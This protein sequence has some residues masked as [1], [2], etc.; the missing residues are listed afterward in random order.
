MKLGFKLSFFLLIAVTQLTYSQ[1]GEFILDTSKVYWSSPFSGYN[2]D[3]AFD[4]TNYLVVWSDFRNNYPYQADIYASRVNQNGDVLDINGIIVCSEIDYQ[5]EVSIAFDGNN[6]LAVWED[7]RNGVTQS[8]IYGARITQTGNVLDPN[9]FVIAANTL[10]EEESPAVSFDGTNYLVTWA[11][12]TGSANNIFGARVSTSGIVIDNPGFMISNT[13]TIQSN[14]E[15]EFDGTNYLV[16]WEDERN[17]NG[18]IYCSRVSPNAVVLDPSGIA[19]TTATQDQL[20]P[21][22]CFG[23]SNSF[24]TWNDL[25]NTSYPN[26]KIYGCRVSPAGSVLDVSGILISD[27][28]LTDRGPSVSFD[29]TNYFIF[30]ERGTIG[31]PINGIPSDFDIYGSRINQQGSVLDINGLLIKES[32]VNA[33]SGAAV[34]LFGLSEYFVAWN[35]TSG[36]TKLLCGRVSQSGILL[37]PP[38]TNVRISINQQTKPAVSSDGLNY[39]AVWQDYRGINGYE[40]YG[41]RIGSDGSI[42]DPSPIAI[43]VNGEDDMYLPDVGFNGTN[44]LV[45]WQESDDLNAVRV[46]TTGV[47]LDSNPIKIYDDTGFPQQRPKVCSD[48]NNWLVVWQDQRPPAGFDTDIYS[49]RI[50]PDGTVLDPQ[51]ILISSASDEQRDPIATFDGQ[52]FMIVWEDE[53]YGFSTCGIYGTR[54]TKEGVV[55]DPSGIQI[56][57][58]EYVSYQNPSIVFNGS[59]YLVIWSGNE[60]IYARRISTDGMLID[61][62]EIPICTEPGNQYGVKVAFNGVNYLAVWDDNRN[63]EQPDIYGSYF[64]SDL[65]IIFPFLVTNTHDNQQSPASCLGSSG[66]ILVTYSAFTEEI[67]G[68]A[69]NTFRIWGIFSDDILGIEDKNNTIPEQYSLYQNY[70]NPFNPS[71]TLSFVIGHSSFVSLKVYDVLG[72]EVATLVNEEKPAGSYKVEFR[73]ENLE[74]SSG[75][76]FY[77]LKA[78]NYIETKKMVLMK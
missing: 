26:Y 23:G 5:D 28:P 19:I 55:L 10:D 57:E 18:D 52:N 29:G 78:S 25:R 30:W 43:A 48:G 7:D 16:V 6:Y 24:I 56:F 75:I 9:G 12:V 46:S 35:E 50:S 45:V 41:I 76:Y 72:N 11:Q 21:S 8:D 69:A 1:N 42:L 63:G 60:N 77:Q 20:A 14:P 53:R 4:G 15:V 40:I 27:S 54:M 3:V 22:I 51:S 68:V 33:S 66:D 13:P 61:P 71:T 32:P 64:D 59:N 49:A 2:I 62:S 37:N 47:V 58:E 34:A 38:G 17:G 65:N 36:L 73:I 39:L 44:Y 67:N 70:P 31:D 74:L